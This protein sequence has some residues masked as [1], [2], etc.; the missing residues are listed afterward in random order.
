MKKSLDHKIKIFIIAY[1]HDS[2]FKKKV[3]G[4]IRMFELADNLTKLGH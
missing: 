3:G 1:W 2:R 4:L